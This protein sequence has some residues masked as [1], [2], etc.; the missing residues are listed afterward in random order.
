MITF[1][2]KMCGGELSF[3]QGASVAECPY[4]GTTQTLP[5]LDNDKRAN[6]Y[7]RANHF[8]RQNE[9]DKA[10]S[11]YEQILQEDRTD[12][13]AYWSLVLCRY[14]IEYVEDPAS[15]KRVP[16][17]NRVQYASILADEDYKSALQYADDEQRRV[18]EAEAD[19]IAEIQKGI[20]DI[21]RQEKPFDVFICYKETD[22]NGRRT[23][24]SVLANDL[25]HQLTNEGFKVFFSRI[26]LEDKLGTAYEPY[27]FAALNSAKVMIVLGTKPEYFN[28]VWVKNEWSRYLALIRA[29]AEKALVP[30]YRDM[31]PYDLPEEFSHLQAQD[32]GKLGFMQDL[33]RGIKKIV[34]SD[35][36]KPQAVVQP[37]VASAGANIENLMKRARLFLEDGDFA[38][39]GEY[40]DKVLDENAE[41]APAYIGKVL[42]SLKLHREEELKTWLYPFEETGDW[43]KALR[44]ATPEQKRAYEGYQRAASDYR[45]EKRKE[46]IYQNAV[47]RYQHARDESQC[48]AAR[49]LFESIHG[50][51]DTEEKIAACKEK[52]LEFQYNDATRMLSVATTVSDCQNARRQFEQVRNYK[53]S[54]AQI[55]ACDKKIEEI[56]N[57]AYER[58]VALQE[59][60][61]W[62]SARNAFWQLGDYKDA[63]AR[64]EE[65]TASEE[66]ARKREEKLAR[67]K[68]ARR[69]RIWIVLILL[70]ILAVAGYIVATKIIIPKMHIDRG[71]ALRDAGQWE[72]AIAEFEQAG[73]Y[74]DAATRIQE[75]Y[76]AIQES[77]YE[78]GIA[79]RAA[80]E[81]DGAVR[82]FEQA[83][84]YSD[85]ETQVLATR[86]AEGEAKR[87]VRDWDEAI[88]AFKS[89]NDYENAITCIADCY[90]QQGMEL[91]NTDILKA[92]LCFMHSGTDS[93]REQIF[94]INRLT[95]DRIAISTFHVVGL[96]SDGTVYSIGDNNRGEC[97][98]GEWTNITAVYAS[99]GSTFGIK[100]NGTVVATGENKKGN[101][102]VS[103]WKDIVSISPQYIHTIGLKS[104]GTVVCAGYS[105]DDGRFNVYS[106]RNIISAETGYNHSV[107]LKS[108]GTVIAVGAEGNNRGQLKTE[109]W[110]DIVMIAA[111]SH[112][113][114]G[115][116]SDGT[117]VGTGENTKEIETLKEWTDIVDI[118]AGY[119]AVGL[120]A[121]GSIVY[122][123][124]R[125]NELDSW[126]DI[127][128]INMYENSIVGLKSD[129]TVVYEN[130]F[131]TDSGHYKSRGSFKL[132]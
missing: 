15:R 111:G 86:Y 50:F 112:L 30:A 95:K 65:C 64:I 71:I 72:E 62:G 3:E 127:V 92:K 100:E 91:I 47:S 99:S 101:L 61:Q 34:S 36:P 19:A 129:G 53:D 74:G 14:G 81:W 89:A 22:A 121:D 31:D 73:D 18:Y 10:M 16:T 66:Q 90:Y 6:L 60:G 39:A 40:L 2:C 41:Y 87:A 21:S 49:R 11:I 128:A 9:Y 46:E 85:A 8:R 17:V 37:V 32:M 118:T 33:I 55:A 69:K 52:A 76:Y 77:Y 126:K 25:Y 26:T 78:E 94:K 106:W 51:R 45:E 113:T 68:A 110:T 120:K 59:E 29:G 57:A 93:A 43:Q 115:L 122:T 12:A 20:L 27:I 75:T 13:E 80:Q 79:K 124:N 109:D 67:K 82:A 38:S 4:C 56:R 58:A 96:N 54:E 102:N 70:A 131:L 117:V 35:E 130:V 108:D 104:N 5:K 98:T 88:R 114:I 97:N 28:A 42:V 103:S 119:S 132:K 107:G 24:D 1:K 125:L 48:E 44:F 23:P 63:R 123:G 116:K 105:G 7:D 83:G 84:N